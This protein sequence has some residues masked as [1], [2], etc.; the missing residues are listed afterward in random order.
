M[1]LRKILCLR[2]TSCS[3]PFFCNSF[4]FVSLLSHIIIVVSIL[5]AWW[6]R[7]S[8]TSFVN[9]CDSRNPQNYVHLCIILNQPNPPNK[10]KLV[11][12]VDV[13]NMPIEATAF[14][15]QACSKIA[16]RCEP[17]TN[18]F[19]KAHMYVDVVQAKKFVHGSDSSFL[20]FCKQRSLTNYYYRLILKIAGNYSCTYVR[21]DRPLC[22]RLKRL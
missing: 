22:S 18:N 16:S 15:K 12:I 17:T 13:Q 21:I 1:V 4:F 3:R 14:L 2:Q 6:G 8:T 9:D 5:R 19:V 10:D 11:K 7:S 20:S